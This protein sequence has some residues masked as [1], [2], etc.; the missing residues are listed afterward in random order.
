LSTYY[1]WET[2]PEAWNKLTVLVAGDSSS[3]KFDPPMVVKYTHSGTKSN[4]GKNYDNA[5]FYL[6][7][8]GHGDL[9]GV[10]SFCVDAKNGEKTSCAN[11]GSTRWVPEF[12]IKKASPVTQVK[13]GS[14]QYLVKPLQIEQTMRKTSSTSVCTG[15]GLSL[16]GVALPDS[17]PYTDPDI[18]ER[19]TVEGPPAVVA[20]AKM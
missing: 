13:D 9:W 1:V 2:G 8:G 7:Y 3:V 4:S 19:P 12:V 6:E 10:P 5:T 14:T 15:A 18:G 17:G 11:D 16:G 20:G